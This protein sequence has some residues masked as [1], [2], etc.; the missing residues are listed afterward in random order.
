VKTPTFEALQAASRSSPS[1]ISPAGA[2]PNRLNPGGSV[3]AAPPRR[4][5]SLARRLGLLTTLIVTGTMAAMSG[6]QLWLDLREDWMQHEKRL[7]E[8]LA[9]LVAELGGARTPDEARETLLRFHRAYSDQGY[10]DHQLSIF[11]DSVER[12]L[13]LRL[14]LIRLCTAS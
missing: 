9:P 12:G 13:L 8:S 11:D 5:P 7:R 2:A 10:P 3:T 14:L 1:G 4:G 6:A